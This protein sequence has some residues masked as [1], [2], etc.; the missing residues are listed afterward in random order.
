MIKQFLEQTL[1]Q[2]TIQF[3][4][5]CKSCLKKAKAAPKQQQLDASMLK[6]EVCKVKCNIAIR[7]RFNILCIEE[8]PKELENSKEQID[9]K[10]KDLRDCLQ[11]AA[12]EVLLMKSK[13][14]K[15]NWMTEQEIEKFEKQHKT[16]E[17]YEKIKNL[18][19]KK[20]TKKKSLLC[21]EK[22]WKTPFEQ[23][24]I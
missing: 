2:I 9:R 23:E 5:K 12:N 18:T 21:N 24:D 19:N 8:Y 15:N 1:T 11:T 17:M 6:Q 7:N 16:K 20:N 4:T 13:R 14:N 10:W 3:S 22:R